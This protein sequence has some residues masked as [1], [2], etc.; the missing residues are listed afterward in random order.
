[1]RDRFPPQLWE[2]TSELLR[3]ARVEPLRQLG[4]DLCDANDLPPR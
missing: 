2:P 1:M 3:P 4:S